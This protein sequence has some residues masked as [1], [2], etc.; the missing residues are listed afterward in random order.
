MFT[1]I[2]EIEVGSPM[3]KIMTKI[4]IT[5]LTRMFTTCTILSLDRSDSR[6]QCQ[7]QYLYNNSSDFNIFYCWCKLWYSTTI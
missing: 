1:I 6:I 7:Y 5:R 4:T 3:K 2:L